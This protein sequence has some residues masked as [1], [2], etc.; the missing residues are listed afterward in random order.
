MNIHL[1]KNMKRLRTKKCIGTNALC[2]S[3]TFQKKNKT[4]RSQC[5]LYLYLNLPSQISYFIGNSFAVFFVASAST[6]ALRVLVHCKVCQSTM[7]MTQ[8]CNIWK[9]FLL[10]F[11]KFFVLLVQVKVRVIL[12]DSVRNFRDKGFTT[13]TAVPVLCVKGPDK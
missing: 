9:I 6:N 11:G 8:S 5:I 2:L 13:G 1:L 3:K 12:Q 7:S 4:F 10:H